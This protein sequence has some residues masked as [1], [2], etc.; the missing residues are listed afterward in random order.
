M[1]TNEPLVARESSHRRHGFRR[2]ASLAPHWLKKTESKGRKREYSR[3]K[4]RRNWVETVALPHKGFSNSPIRTNKLTMTAKQIL[5]N[6]ACDKPIAK[7]HRD[8]CNENE[9]ENFSEGNDNDTVG[10][11]KLARQQTQNAKRITVFEHAPKTSKLYWNFRGNP[12]TPASPRWA[13]VEMLAEH[14]V[15]WAAS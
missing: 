11:T 7:W 1:A 4:Y 12:T 6:T 13:L 5:I 2:S 9:N 3:V 8:K 15:G 10:Q 14:A